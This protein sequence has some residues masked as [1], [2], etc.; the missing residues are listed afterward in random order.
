MKK[1]GLLLFLVTLAIGLAISS[2]SSWGSTSSKLFNF[3]LNIGGEKG[4]GRIA[5]ESRDLA[6]FSSIDV[7]GVFQVEV[8]VQKDFA[9]E[10]EADDNL[11]PLIM[12]E[13]RNGVLVIKAE[14]KLKSKN[15]I[16]VRVSVPELNGLE[17]SG[18]AK[19]SVRN[20]R[21]ERF[22]I[23][24]SGA[25]K[26]SVEGEASDL[27]LEVSGASKING[28][29]LATENANIEA[30]GASHV[31]INVSGELR[32]DAS[33]ASSIAYSGSPSNVIKHTSGAATV[34]AR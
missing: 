13:V 26:I 25:S 30:S 12:T 18:A 16:K 11:L 22:A 24:A 15:P 23:D 20:L 21:N 3:P 33:G 19:V 8:V 9:V 2:L 32:T 34:S 14:K 28:E 29:D 27:T 17:V 6:G 1:I 31:S 5:S 10:L 4:S 7:G